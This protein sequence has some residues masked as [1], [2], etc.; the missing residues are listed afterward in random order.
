MARRVTGS[1]VRG[2]A[3]CAL[4]LAS[5]R[6]AAQTEAERLIEAG[7]WKQARTIVEARARQ[8][9]DALTDFLLSQIH[10]AFGDHQSPLP[11]AEKAVALDGTVA[12]YHRQI[13]E[14]TGVMAQH[15]GLFQQLLLARRF[16][17]EI[18]AA[19]SLDP[20]DVQALRDLMEF[21]LLAPGIVGGDRNKAPAT[22]I[23]IARVDPLEGYL[24]HA[25]LAEAA[26]NPAHQ[27][28]MLRKAVES[29]PSHYRARVAL[30]GFLLGHKNWQ[31]ASQQA[32]IAVKIDCQRVDGYT[33]LAAAYAY[34][35]RTGEL[36][37]VLRAAEK[38]VSDD[39]SPY[40]RAAE[41]LF[42][43]GQ[44]LDRAQRYFHRYLAAPPEGNAPTLS[45]AREKLEQV[46]AKTKAINGTYATLG[47]G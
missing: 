4:L 31:G 14:V 30:A 45:E 3:A 5:W 8:S 19:L 37:S 29:G 35:G 7:H 25:R 44:D 33:I 41:A 21:Y 11:L 28:A 18:D 47:P 46:V 20:R 16:R 1:G 15:A 40:Y 6:C 17:G 39:L 38:Q 43:A 12:K 9:Q 10:N 36:E 2:V 34:L 42:V 32:E 22:A 23:R 13:A 27:E 24:A 26:G